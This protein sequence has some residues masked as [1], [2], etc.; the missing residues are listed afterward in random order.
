MSINSSSRTKKVQWLDFE[1]P[2]ERDIELLRTKFGFHEVILNEIK[3]PSA[4]S[5]VEVYDDYLYLIYYFP[6]YNAKEETSRRAEVDF[7]ITKNALITIHYEPLEAL[8][9]IAKAEA[10]KAEKAEKAAAR[11]DRSDDEPADSD[12]EK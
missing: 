8:Q 3:D 1:N 5:H 9:A 4:R 12:D 7:L 6:I 10:A 2:S 11:G